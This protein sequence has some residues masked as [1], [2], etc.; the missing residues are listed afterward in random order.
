MEIECNFS[1]GYENV[2][3]CKAVSWNDPFG[4]KSLEGRNLQVGACEDVAGTMPEEYPV[5][6]LPSPLWILLDAW[7]Q[8]IHE[9]KIDPS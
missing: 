6:K 4:M 2:V 3:S 9:M 7:F 5:G 8:S 1:I